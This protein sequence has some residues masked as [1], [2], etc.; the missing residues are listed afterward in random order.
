MGIFRFEDPEWLVAL[1]LIPL[2]V[3]RYVLELRGDRGAIQFSSLAMISALPMTVWTRLRHS[4]HILK[5]AGLVCLIVAL[6]RPQA[7]KEMVDLSAEGVDIMLVLDISGSME[8]RDIGRTSRLQ[9]AKEVVA[10]FI[11]GRTSDRI[12]M[13]VFA[14]ESFTQCPLTLDY[15][16]LLNFL[17]DICIA[18][19]SWDGTAIGMA[20]MN[21]SNRLRDS[22]AQSKVVVLL[23]DGVNNAGEIAP[24]TAAQVAAALGIRVYTVGVGYAAVGSSRVRPAAARE[25][26]FDEQTLRDISER[27]QGKYFHATSKEKLEEIYREIGE[28]EMTEI[29]SEIH[30]DYTE[31]YAL[32]LWPGLIFLLLEFV[33]ANTKFRRIP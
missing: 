22:D 10:E 13:V 9:V 23:T 16:I 1:V 25:L 31:R 8:A 17:R 19:Q 29:T 18:E 5:V 7:G 32:F 11:Q 20:L 3:Y 30:V 24:E 14:G 26:A 27:T 6:A 28:L 4:L 33:L 12:G 15:D 21:A 2:L